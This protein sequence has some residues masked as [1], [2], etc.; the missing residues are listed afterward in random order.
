MN[1]LIPIIDANGNRA[2]NA[3]NLYERLKVTTRFN[4]WILRRITEYGFKDGED[5]YSKLSKSMG[6]RPATEYI[7]TI[8]MAKEL[9]MLEN[10]EI[11][12]EIRRYLIAIERACRSLEQIRALVAE[13]VQKVFSLAA[14]LLM[15]GYPVEDG[16]YRYGRRTPCMIYRYIYE[17]GGRGYAIPGKNVRN[18]FHVLLYD[19]QGNFIREGVASRRLLDMDA[20]MGSFARGW[21]GDYDL[22]P[23]GERQVVDDRDVFRWFAEL[24]LKKPWAALSDTREPLPDNILE[25]KPRKG[26]GA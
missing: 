6:G 10:N 22:G 21:K 16:K 5:F 9:A 15:Y 19:N 20:T 24:A 17:S 26:L 11:G 2:V 14:G 8:D 23:V 1:E 12:R 7:L 25:F 18:G 4:D 3:R 13:G